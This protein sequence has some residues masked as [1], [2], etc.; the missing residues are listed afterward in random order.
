MNYKT[1]MYMYT[2]PCSTYFY[3]FVVN[4]VERREVVVVVS[5]EHVG[6]R[7]A[8]GVDGRVDV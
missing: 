6:D 8:D 2:H 1:W 4:F 5:V 3:V 7:Q